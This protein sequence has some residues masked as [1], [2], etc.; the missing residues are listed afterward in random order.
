MYFSSIL[1]QV[2]SEQ[3]FLTFYLLWVKKAIIL[4]VIV[5]GLLFSEIL[6]YFYHYIMTQTHQSST[7]DRTVKKYFASRGPKRWNEIL[8]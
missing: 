4:R 7:D 6:L 1:T 3:L 5:N 2:L 8:F